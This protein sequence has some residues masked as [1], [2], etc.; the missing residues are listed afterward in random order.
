MTCVLEID[1]S[2]IRANYQYLARDTGRRI[3]GVVKA[4]A[5][6]LGA[7]KVVSELV[8]VGCNEFFVANAEEGKALRSEFDEIILYV[9][10]GALE[11]TY[12]KLL[13]HNLRPVL[14][15]LLQCDLW[16]KQSAPCAI[17]LDSGMERLG[18]NENELNEM[19]N[20]PK[21]LNIQLLM[22]HLARA[23]EPDHQFNQLQKKRFDLIRQRLG[24][25]YPEVETSLTNSAGV[26]H[27]DY[28]DDLGR[29]GIALY[30]GNPF[31]DRSNPMSPVVRLMAQ[32][33][34]VRE[35]D[36][37]L[38]VGYGGTF[39]TDRDSV[40]AIIGAGY[41]DGIS[42]SLS[43]KG[44]TFVSG[45]Y[46]PIVGRISM[47]T[48]HV[49]VTGVDIVEGDWVELIGPNMSLDEVALQSGTISYE[50]LTGLGRRC[51]RVYLGSAV[52]GSR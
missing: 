2:A 8:K 42:R 49:D 30:G 20:D 7:V 34:Q 46:C 44:R 35:V 52:Q 19:L 13:E 1:L 6:G 32:A 23:D 25:L 36:T 17:H 18:L 43:N 9:L 33:L 4:D 48:L 27:Q 37:G 38:P 21:E 51:S 26:A 12:E 11:S 31:S 10:E 50:V 41:A 16:S 5:Y 15:T 24:D 45:S 40:L 28:V 3:A 14:N 47:D 29:P 22:S 39:V